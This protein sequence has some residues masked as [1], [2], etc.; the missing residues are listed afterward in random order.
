MESAIGMLKPPSLF[1]DSWG[2]LMFV[3]VHAQ[4][5]ALL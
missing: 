3:V 1:A 5:L 2:L 4:R